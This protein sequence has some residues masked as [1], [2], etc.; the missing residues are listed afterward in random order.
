MVVFH[1]E[2]CKK[3]FDEVV[4]FAKQTN[5][6]HQ[7]CRQIEYLGMYGDSVES[8]ARTGRHRTACSL[9]KDFAPYSFTFLMQVWNEER[10]A[11]TTWF[12]GGLIYQ[13]PGLPTDGSFPSL[14]VS[15]HNNQGWFVHT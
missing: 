3:H 11:Y 2:T 7:L 13:G 4:K 14:T 10:Q 1:N 5:Q 9:Y 6:L 15:L 12:N 8:R